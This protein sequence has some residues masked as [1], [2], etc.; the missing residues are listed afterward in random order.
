MMMKEQQMREKKDEE[1]QGIEC[2]GTDGKRDMKTKKVSVTVN[3][4]EQEKYSV[5][6]EELIVYTSEPVG[7]YLC[8]STPK[9]GKGQ[10]LAVDFVENLAEN[11][12]TSSLK[13]ILCDVTATM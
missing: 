8:H 3:G 1:V 11:W 7:E 2:I 13:A 10:G 5:G 9:N 6:P 12:S 4:I